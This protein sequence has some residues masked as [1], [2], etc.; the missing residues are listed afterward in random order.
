MTPDELI[1]IATQAYP[2]ENL[3]ACEVL[4]L[5]P[6]QNST[7]VLRTAKETSY[8]LRIYGQHWRSPARIFYEI[9]LLQHLAKKGVAVSTALQRRDG[10]FFAPLLPGKDE[11]YLALF[12]FAPGERC[13]G[14]SLREHQIGYHFG[15]AVAH[16]HTAADNFTC[17]HKPLLHD[18]NYLLY[19]P[20]AHLSPWLQ[21]RPRDLEYLHTLTE[22]IHRALTP[23]IETG[24]NWGVCHGDLPSGNAFI[25]NEG[26][27]TFFDFDMC[28]MGWRAAELSQIREGAAWSN[29]PEI[30][31]HFLE[32]YQEIRPLRASDREAIPWFVATGPIW[33]LGD[34]AQEATHGSGETLPDELVDT[35][36]SFPRRWEERH[37]N[38]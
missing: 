25:T 38:E 35:M 2:V 24:L 29:E 27:V 13:T 7:Y 30:W 21:H 14:G 37:V 33:Y 15:R 17:P 6:H 8:I 23:L 12:T 10:Q 34:Q 36:L 18:L 9:S 26:L 1:A 20:L 22:R 32:G 3:C 4:R 31:L 19:E 11:R 5:H 16:L 28:G